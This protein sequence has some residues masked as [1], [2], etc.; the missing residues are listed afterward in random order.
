MLILIIGIIV[1]SAAATLSICMCKA[2]SW[3]DNIS[4]VS[5]TTIK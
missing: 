2:A 3:A 1:S 5:E 4:T